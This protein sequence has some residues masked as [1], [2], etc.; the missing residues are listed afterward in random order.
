MKTG[1]FLFFVTLVI[2]KSLSELRDKGALGFCL[3]GARQGGP[4]RKLMHFSGNFLMT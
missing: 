2:D 4:H 3:D 1:S